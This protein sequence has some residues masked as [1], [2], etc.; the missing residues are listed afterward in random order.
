M[1]RTVI[2]TVH[3]DLDNIIRQMRGAGSVK[4]GFIGGRYQNG[5]SIVKVA[6]WNEFGTENIPERPFFRQSN[7]NNN[8]SY[9]QILKQ[10]AVQRNYA[11]GLNI[12]GQKAVGDIQQSINTLSSPENKQST[13]D[14]KGSSNPLIDTGRF[15][16]SV[17]Y[18]RI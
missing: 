18:E 13:I 14:A 5:Q 12:V 10:A 1:T 4:Y 2:R 17:S 16:Q 15:K 11:S 7:N 6:I 3:L 8:D 9:A